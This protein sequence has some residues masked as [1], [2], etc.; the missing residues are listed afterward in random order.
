MGAV[1][2]A[3]YLIFAASSANAVVMGF[4]NNP[5]GNSGDWLTSVA[6]LSGTVNSNVNFDTHAPGA[7]N[8]AF[9]TGTDGVTLIGTGNWA[10]VSS[11]NG[12]GQ[13]NTT[14]IPVSPG[15]GLHAASNF[16][17]G[18]T[19]GASTLTIDFGT[20]VLGV[21]LSSIDL[22]DPNSSVLL[23]IEA[24]TGVGGTGTSLG[25]FSNAQFNF[26]ANNVYF[27]GVTSSDN[28]IRSLVVSHNGQLSDIVGLDD[29]VFATTSNDVPEPGTLALFGVGLAGLGFARRKRVG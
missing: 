11:G 29:I 22:Y 21:G 17:G 27:M 12:P 26:Q 28:D 9:Y 13:G 24:F 23:T 15:E 10:T 14:S 16:L 8:G 2:A 6:G 4:V 7:L 25:L 5:T 19:F 18:L 1:L 20:S 3:G